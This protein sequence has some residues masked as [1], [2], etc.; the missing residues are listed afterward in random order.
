MYISTEYVYNPVN[1]YAQTKKMAEALVVTGVNPY[2]IIS[3][4]FKPSPF[5]F[6]KAFI[7]QYTMGDYVDVIA[8]MIVDEIKRWDRKTNKLVDVGTGRK[9]I[10]ELAKRTRP[11]V[12]PCSVDDIK[13]VKLPKDYEC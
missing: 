7:D 1:W 9:T 10:F 13:G 12:K 8:P 6:E 4:L 5:P 2:L 11:D 3:T